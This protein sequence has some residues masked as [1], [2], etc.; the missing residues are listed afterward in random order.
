M[1][2]ILIT[3]GCGFIGSN[4]IAHIFDKYDYNIWNIDSLTYAANISNLREEIRQSSRY[5]FLDCDINNFKRVRD[6]VVSNE[7]KF[8]VN[9]AAESHVDN[10]I[11][12]S[13]PFIHSNI[14]GTHNLLTILHDYGVEKYLQISTDEVYGSL[15]EEDPAFTEGHTIR[16]NSPYAASKASADLLCRSFFKTYG[17][18][19]AITRCSNNYGPNQHPEKLIPL[20]IK[21]AKKGLDIPIYGDGRNIRDW[22]H[23]A[24][25]CEAIDKVL[26]D[27]IPG[28][29]YNI[30]GKNE[31]RNIDIVKTILSL[32]NKST[33]Q[34]KF[35][36]DRAGHDWRY[37]IDNSKISRELGWNPKINFKKGLLKLL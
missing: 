13:S 12:N 33:D 28:E 16:P 32:L 29:I 3:G 30:G 19:I 5:H 6:T 26:H 23:V 18:P 8:I 9:F 37:A 17:Y 2:N 15:K 21:N 36:E 20:V 7:I 1:K 10:S 4:F 35:A 34:I 11:S 31:I 25:H 27:G 14:N 24:D 22:I